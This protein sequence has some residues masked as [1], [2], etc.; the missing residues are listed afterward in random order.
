MN[1]RDGVESFSKTLWKAR[2][3]LRIKGRPHQQVNHH[4]IQDQ[5]NSLANTMCYEMPLPS[6]ERTKGQSNTHR[7]L[8]RKIQICAIAS[9]SAEKTCHSAHFLTCAEPRRCNRD[10]AALLDFRLVLFIQEILRI[11]SQRT[12]Q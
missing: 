11:S 9:M 1:R 6:K 2:Q 8:N 7:E 4:Q 5:D 3:H 12:P 10:P